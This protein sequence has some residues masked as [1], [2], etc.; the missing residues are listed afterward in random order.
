MSIF[1]S[2]ITGKGICIPVFLCILFIQD[3]WEGVLSTD[4]PISAVFLF[5]NSG[6]TFAK[7]INSVVQTGVRC[8][9]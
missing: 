9:M 6:Y 2:E 7:A 3:K 8:L 4:S 5:S 1:V